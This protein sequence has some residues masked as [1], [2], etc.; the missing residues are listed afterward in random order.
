MTYNRALAAPSPRQRLIEEARNA[1]EVLL[2]HRDVVVAGA[3]DEHEFKL[4]TL[5][6]FRSNF[7]SS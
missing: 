2:R 4:I 7:D 6:F 5:T 3:L 1:L